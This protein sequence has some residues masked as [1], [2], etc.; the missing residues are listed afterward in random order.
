MAGEMT[1]GGYLA[2][3]ELLHA[4]GHG[5]L[6]WATQVALLEKAVRLARP[7]ACLWLIWQPGHA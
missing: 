5:Y 7:G 6:A 4:T 1:Y 2:L 3:D